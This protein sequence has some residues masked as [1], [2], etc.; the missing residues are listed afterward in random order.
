MVWAA[1]VNN[2]RRVIYDTNIILLMEKPALILEILL[3]FHII[4]VRYL[5]KHVIKNSDGSLKTE[6]RVSTNDL[7]VGTFF[8][9]FKQ[10]ELIQRI[11]NLG[12]LFSKKDS[13]NKDTNHVDLIQ[14]NKEIPFTDRKCED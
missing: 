9:S 8:I 12:H 10:L 3:Y 7:L 5:L 2:F 4:D 13:I 14:K 6:N 11:L 1:R